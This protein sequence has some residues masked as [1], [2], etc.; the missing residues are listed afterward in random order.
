MAE[1]I[2]RQRLAR[3]TI[4]LKESEIH[5]QAVLGCPYRITKTTLALFEVKG[6]YVARP[7]PDGAIIRFDPDTLPSKIMVEVLFEDHVILM[8]TQDLKTVAVLTD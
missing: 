4:S 2:W 6:G 3:K 8:F 5:P 1:R 7:V